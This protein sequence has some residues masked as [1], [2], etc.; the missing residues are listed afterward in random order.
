[1]RL[2]VA[3]MVVLAMGGIARADGAAIFNSNCVICHQADATGLSGMYPPLADSIGSYVAIPRGR[4]YLVHVVSFGMT[5]PI[6]VHDQIYNG[7]MYPWPNFTDEDIAQVLNYVLTS[8]NAKLLPKDFAPLTV[9]E[10]KKYR[11]A[12]TAMGDVHQER[13]ALIKALAAV[14]SRP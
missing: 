5:G 2:L 14:K 8:F 10:V 7:V 13:E 4:A 1:L 3:L 12:N 9:E 6:A 11:T